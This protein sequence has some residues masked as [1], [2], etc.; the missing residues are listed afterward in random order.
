MNTPTLGPIIRRSGIAGFYE[1]HTVATYSHDGE[2]TDYRVAFTGSV[3][4]APVVMITEH[5][6]T[7]VTDWTRHGETLDAD[8]VRR[9]FG[10]E[11]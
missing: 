11:A 8:W 3:Y 10:I 7:L 9:F 5:G 1:L 6:Q 2:T 4:G